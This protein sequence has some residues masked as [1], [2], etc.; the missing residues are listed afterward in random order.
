ML[1]ARLPRLAV[2]VLTLGLVVAGLF[3]PGVVGAVL[4]LVVG[5]LMAWLLNV[6]WPVL[7]AAA[8]V[9]RVL[10]VALVLGYA[11]YKAKVGSSG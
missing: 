11:A 5:L 3:F 9:P 4:L 7:P 1:L 8:R 10:T 2:L 6:A